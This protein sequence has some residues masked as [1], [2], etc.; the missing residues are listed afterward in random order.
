MAAT[1]SKILSNPLRTHTNDGPGPWN[2]IVENT[3]SMLG[4]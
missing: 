4:Y 2:I 3:D 1:K